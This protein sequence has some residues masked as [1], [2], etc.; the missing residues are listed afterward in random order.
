MHIKKLDYLEANELKN[1][2]K[3]IFGDKFTIADAYLYIVLSWSPYLKLDFSKHAK[4]QK[5]F[6]G[7]K[8]LDFVVKAHEKMNA[9][10]K[11]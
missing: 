3:Y 7:I 6:D 1:S 8:G 10:A 9:A 2:P 5:Y 4:V 11:K